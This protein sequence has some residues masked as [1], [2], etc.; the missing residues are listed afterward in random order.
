MKSSML[1]VC[2]AAV[3][4]LARVA[5]ESAPKNDGQQAMVVEPEETYDV[6]WN[7]IKRDLTP[8]LLTMTQRPVDGEVVIARTFNLEFRQFWE[9][10]GRALLLDRPPRLSPRPIP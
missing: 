9:D 10:W 1:K 2:S 7:A 3:L 5:C 4:G 6:S 8:E